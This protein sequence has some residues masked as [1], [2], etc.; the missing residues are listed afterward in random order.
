M[1]N[2]VPGAPAAALLLIA[3]LALGSIARAQ[4]DD[5]LLLRPTRPAPGAPAAF[6]IDTFQHDTAFVKQSTAGSAEPDLEE[7]LLGTRSWRVTTGGDGVQVNLRADGLDPLDLSDAFLRLDLKVERLG[8]LRWLY[9]YLSDDGFETYDTYLMLRGDYPGAEAYA[10]DGSWTTITSALGTPLNGDPTVDLTRVTGIQ[11]SVV[12]AGSEPAT[13]WLAGLE[14]VDRPERGVVTVMFDDARSGVFELAVPLAQRFGVR[15]SVAV[16]AD[17][18]GA[19]GFMTLEQLRLVERFGGWEV[20]AHHTSELATGGFDVLSAEELTAEL[21]GIKRWMI[22]NGFQRGADVIAY[23][24]GGFHDAALEEVRR[25]FGAGRTILRSLG[26]E[27]FPPADPYRIRAFSVT[28]RDTT[29]TIKAAIDRAARERSW[30]VLV[31][32]QFS[33]A[34]A[35]Y[36]TEYSGI[37]FAVVMAHLVAAD[38]EVLTFSEAALGR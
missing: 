37:D 28:D 4:A 33:N 29:D 11:L 9:L 12:D 6:V 20:V 13:V 24:Y 35:A 7:V 21:V 34:Q 2:H 36:D 19:P 15:A 30:L 10:D 8:S 27:T 16:I 26:L 22:L 14:A 1:P 23:P 17:L 38:V 18:V 3:C 32:H 31:F 5:A 25:Y